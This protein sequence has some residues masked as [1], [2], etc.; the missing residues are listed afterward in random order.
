MV[1]IFFSFGNLTEAFCNVFNDYFLIQMNTNATRMSN[2]SSSTG[3][4]LDLLLI[5]FD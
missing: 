3:N 1:L 5:N 4:M 2:S